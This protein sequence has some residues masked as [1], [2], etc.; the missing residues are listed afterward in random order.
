ML[1]FAVCTMYLLLITNRVRLIDRQSYLMHFQ[2]N[3]HKK[4]QQSV[5]IDND[6]VTGNRPNE[7]VRVTGVDKTFSVCFF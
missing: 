7:P 1:K 4:A 6:V 3:M 2:S 5:S